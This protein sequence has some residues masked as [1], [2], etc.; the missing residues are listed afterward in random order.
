MDKEELREICISACS[1][2]LLEDS[3]LTSTVIS[4]L[5]REMLESEIENTSEGKTVN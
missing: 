5:V 2:V 4:I 1:D 3:A